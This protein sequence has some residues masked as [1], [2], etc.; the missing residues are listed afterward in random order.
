MRQFITCDVYG[1]ITQMYGSSNNEDIHTPPGFTRI[2]VPEGFNPVGYYVLEGEVVALPTR[3][4]S[5]HVFNYQTLIWEDPRT[6]E[7]CKV[8]Q[9]EAIKT[10]RT[11]EEFGCFT[12]NIF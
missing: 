8:L 5:I 1:K 11:V 7:E 10:R 9:W 6:L 12:Y 2:E 3:P 4:S